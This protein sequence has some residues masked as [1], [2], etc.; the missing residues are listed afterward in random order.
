MLDN[1]EVIY[2][3]Y[4]LAQLDIDAVKAYSEA[5]DRI[6]V[7]LIKI[8][9]TNF[10]R[11]HEQHITDLSAIIKALGGVAPYKTPDLKGFIIQG[12]TALWSMFG[13]EAALKAMKG[14][15]ELT[16]RTYAKAL[17]LDLPEA[18][19]VVVQRNFE[20]ERRHLDYINNCIRSKVWEEGKAA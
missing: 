4:S 15:E 9:L 8:Q 2:H 16:N 3:L 7:G 11:D 18:V 14:N 20:D 6:H 13:T 12:F 19:R 10:Q 17:E 1:S 5:I